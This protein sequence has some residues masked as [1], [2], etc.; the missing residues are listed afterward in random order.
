MIITKAIKIATI[1]KAILFFMFSLFFKLPLLIF[2][3][4]LYK[5]F[6]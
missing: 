4:S 3:M 1:F 2:G 6:G 5:F